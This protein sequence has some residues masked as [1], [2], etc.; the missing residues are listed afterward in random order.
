MK[1]ELL[2]EILSAFEQYR[3]DILN[4]SFDMREIFTGIL[5]FLIEEL[6]YEIEK[7]KTNNMYK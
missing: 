3:K 4:N 2:K 5:T 6:K 1:I 7:N